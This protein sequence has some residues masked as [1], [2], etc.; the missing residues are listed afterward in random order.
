MYYADI[1]SQNIKKLLKAHH[2]SIRQLAEAI[3][4]SA[5]TLTD[6]LMSKNGISLDTMMNIAN[7]FG[8]SADMLCDKDFDV[9]HYSVFLE[10]Y[11][12]YERSYK[13]LD[14]H[15]RSVVDAVFRLELARCTGQRCAIRPAARNGRAAVGY[16]TPAELRRGDMELA[17]LAA[18]GSDEGL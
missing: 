14:D 16:P 4:I 1:V 7:H 15:G 11:T 13:M 12:A 6:S 17:R 9:E 5:S 3:S 2:I 8:V 10:D 18:Q